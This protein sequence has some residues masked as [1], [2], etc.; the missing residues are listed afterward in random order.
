[1][2]CNGEV[3]PLLIDPLGNDEQRLVSVG[4]ESVDGCLR[5]SEDL[6]GEILVEQQRRGKAALTYRGEL[7]CRFD[8][9][10]GQLGKVVED[11]RIR[12]RSRRARVW[13]PAGP[14]R[15]VGGG[16]SPEANLG[17]SSTAM[18]QTCSGSTRW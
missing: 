9:I 5:V 7:E 17:I 3:C 13:D 1:V 18:V 14:L 11:R 2:A 4:D 12:S 10:G 15:Y 6:P 16:P 8:V